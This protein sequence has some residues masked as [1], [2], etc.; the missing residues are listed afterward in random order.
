MDQALSSYP[1]S[2]C[3][4]Y[5]ILFPYVTITLRKMALYGYAIK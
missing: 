3:S 2:Y 1:Q 4:K 5:R